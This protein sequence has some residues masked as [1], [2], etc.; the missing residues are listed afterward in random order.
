MRLPSLSNRVGIVPVQRWR[1]MMGGAP[2][3]ATHS[4]AGR[5]TDIMRKD[6]SGAMPE[7]HPNEVERD[8][9]AWWRSMGFYKPEFH[10]NGEPFVMVMPPPNV[11]GSLHLGHALM[12]S[13]ED[14]LARWHRM[15]GK[16]VLWV[17]GTDHAG[18]ATQVVVEKKIMRERNQTRHDL[19]REAFL[20]EVWNWKNQYGDTICNQLRS[21]GVSADWDREA[22]TMDERLSQAVKQAFLRM[23]ASGKIYRANRLVNWSPCLRTAISDIEVEH[24]E[25]EEP[26]KLVVPGHARPIE[27]GVY[28]SFSYQLEGSSDPADRITVATTRIETM[29]GDVA[30]AVHPKDPRY[31]RFHGKFLSHPF[32][33]DRRVAVITDDVLVDMEKGTGAVKVTPAHDP[34]DFEC[35]KR[36]NLEQISVFD[37]DGRINANGGPEFAGM[38]RFDARFAVIKRLKELDLYGERIPNPGMRLGICSRSSDIIEPMCKPQWWVDCKEMAGRAAQAV[39]KG[40]LEIVPKTHENI[41]FQW[42]DNIRDWCISRQ[43]WWGHRIPAY[44]VVLDGVRQPAADCNMKYWIVAGS[45]EEA[46]NIALER[47]AGIDASRIAILQDEDVLDTWFSSGLFPF[48][49]MDWPNTEAEDYRKYYPNQLLETGGD[50]LFFWVARMVMMGL[51]L[52]GSLPFKQVFLHPMVRDAFG[53]KMSKSLCNVIDPLDVIH[54]ISLENLNDKVKKSGQSEKEIKRALAEQQKAYAKTKGIPECGTD[55]LRLG[56]LSYTAQGRNINLDVNR[57]LG[58]RHFCN[59]LWNAVRFCMPR[60]GSSVVIFPE[61]GLPSLDEALDTIRIAFASGSDDACTVYDRW[62][63]SRLH[64]TS[65]TANNALKD[66]DFATATSAMY[67]FMLN[68]FCG[69]YLETTKPVFSSGLDSHKN[70]ARMVLYVCLDH[71]LKLLHPVMPFVTEEL[72]QRLPITRRPEGESIMVQPY[73]QG[74]AT[75]VDERAEAIVDLGSTLVHAI[76]GT[77]SGL[78]ISPKSRCDIAVQCQ[79]SEDEK[80]VVACSLMVATLAKA[81]KVT[82]LSSDSRIPSGCAPCIV[83]ESITAHLHVAGLIDFAKELD[84]LDKKRSK[85]AESIGRTTARTSSDQYQNNTPAHVREKEEAALEKLRA[86]LA[87]IDTAIDSLKSLSQGN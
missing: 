33:P 38:M 58:Y 55:G 79:T 71:I 40:D 76:L 60:D 7:Y 67:D 52:T 18:I 42:L 21:L 1:S 70:V 3:P 59:K 8:W 64:R 28:H 32:F 62:I 13:I 15:C 34:N 46:M 73:P 30:V 37:E 85:L 14:C 23:F 9:Q 74:E 11:T 17:P 84:R 50:I 61:S 75:F 78:G 53:R 56:L 49:V 12:A 81:D 26:K 10:P 66:Y 22:F 35:G 51:E 19:G 87:S 44:E 39:R 48:S 36:H 5:A 54:G 77:R 29:L 86:E 6:V 24:I 63:M 83:T 57:V 68:E 69:V 47:F 20:Q 45:E 80:H 65:F 2:Q 25:L 82:T 16:Q 27:F 72:W 41:W 4:P 43:L 31:T